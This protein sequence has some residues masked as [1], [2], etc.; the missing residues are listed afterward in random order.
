MR[1]LNAP[2]FP[3]LTNS[4]VCKQLIAGAQPH[5]FVTDLFTGKVEPVPFVH[6]LLHLS[7][8]DLMAVL[9]TGYGRGEHN[10]DQFRLKHDIE[11]DYLRDHPNAFYRQALASKG[12]FLEHFKQDSDPRVRRQVAL[13]DPDWDTQGDPSYMVREPHSSVE[14]I[15]VK[16]GNVLHASYIHTYQPFSSLQATSSI[17]LVKSTEPWTLTYFPT[18]HVTYPECW[19]LTAP[20]VKT[21]DLT[22]FTHHDIIGALDKY[23]LVW[24]SDPDQRDQHYPYFA[25]SPIPFTHSD[26]FETPM[27]EGEWEILVAPVDGKRD[28]PVQAV[29]LIPRQ[30]GGPHRL[31]PGLVPV[32]VPV[33]T[34]LIEPLLT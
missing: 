6:N 9:E 2:P 20:G 33:L 15:P 31:C 3:I 12:Y 28:G 32:E 24:Y 5:D 8:Q 34:A 7:D 25:T 23:P 21:I 17:S 19:L 10:L 14:Q 18:G 29:L 4:Q 16:L 26:T 27:V 1:Q 22:G 13:N 11:L 30:Q